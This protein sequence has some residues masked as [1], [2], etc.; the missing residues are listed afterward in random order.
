MSPK[1]VHR[2]HLHG[3]LHQLINNLVGTKSDCNR[4]ARKI[5]LW[6]YNKNVWLS[7]VRLPGEQN[8]VADRESRSVHDNMEWQLNPQLFTRICQRFGTP[9]IDLFAS[10]LNTQLQQYIAWKP[11][12]GAIAVEAMAENWSPWFF[13][14]FPP[15]NMVG[16]VLHKI[17][18]DQA[19]GILVVPYWPTQS[20]FAKFTKLCTHTPVIAFSRE[21]TPTL[22][23]PNRQQQEL[24]RTRLMACHVSGRKGDNSQH[25]HEQSIWPHGGPPRKNSTR[26]TSQSGIHIVLQGTQVLCHPL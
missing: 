2:Q 18:R 11:D 14:A 22:I 23:H 8:V 17:E 25:Q 20:W 7:A 5:W 19:S 1:I 15:F 4:I 16:R 10:R 24:P 9:Q 13:Y 21:I 26:R 12:P 6:C 3:S